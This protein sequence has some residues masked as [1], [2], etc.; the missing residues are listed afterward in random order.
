LA[1]I[2]GLLLWLIYGLI[3]HNWP[4]ILANSVTLTFCFALVWMKVTY[5]PPK[6]R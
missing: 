3:L 1:F 2:G 4:M 5:H 6:T